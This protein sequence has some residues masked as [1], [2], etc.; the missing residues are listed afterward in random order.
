MWI[1][2]YSND[3]QQNTMLRS[4]D[5]V[6]NKCKGCPSV[7]ARTFLIEKDV[8]SCIWVVSSSDV[9]VAII[10]VVQYLFRSISA[11]YV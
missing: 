5:Y 3:A 9:A 7:I 2:N 4:S 8:L 11:C 6:V 1:W 10:Q